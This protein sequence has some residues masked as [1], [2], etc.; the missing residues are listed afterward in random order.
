MPTTYMQLLL[1][2]YEDAIPLILILV[3]RR[4][5]DRL[6]QISAGPVSVSFAAPQCAHCRSIL[7][8]RHRGGPRREGEG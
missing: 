3:V 1:A 6:T 5:F 2:V 8:P 4:Q 7:S